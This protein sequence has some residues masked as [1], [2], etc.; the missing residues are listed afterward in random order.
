MRLLSRY[1]A[2]N[3][4]A[5]NQSLKSLECRHSD[6]CDIDVELNVL[7]VI[8]S[9]YADAPFAQEWLEQH[10]SFRLTSEI[11]GG[12]H[13]AADKASLNIAICNRMSYI[14][15]QGNKLQ[16][17]IGVV[18]FQNVKVLNLADNNIHS[19]SACEPLSVLAQLEELRLAGN[20]VQRLIHYRAHLIRICS[21]RHSTCPRFQTTLKYLDG[22]QIAEDECT[23]SYASLNLEQAYFAPALRHFVLH[24]IVDSFSRRIDLHIEMRRRGLL[25]SD[26]AQPLSFPVVM[27]MC[28]D[29]SQATNITSSLHFQCH[30]EHQLRRLSLSLRNSESPTRTFW[31]KLEEHRFYVAHAAT[32]ASASCLGAVL[33]LA[34]KLQASQL[35]AVRWYSS[36]FSLQR[37]PCDSPPPVPRSNVCLE[38]NNQRTT[39]LAYHTK[40]AQKTLRRCLFT[41]KCALDARRHCKR[42]VLRRSLRNWVACLRRTI[43]CR[44]L[45]KSA[46][47]FQTKHYL[48]KWKLRVIHRKKLTDNGTALFNVTA[49]ASCGANQNRASHTQRDFTA[50]EACRIYFRMWV[51]FTTTRPQSKIEPEREHIDVEGDAAIASLLPDEVLEQVNPVSSKGVNVQDVHRESTKFIDSAVP[52]QFAQ[53]SETLQLEKLRLVYLV[54]TLEKELADCRLQT[55]KLSAVIDSQRAEIKSLSTDRDQAHDAVSEY[56]RERMIHLELIKKLTLNQR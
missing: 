5:I 40:V 56:E 1:V 45:V 21:T 35:E 28:V 4:D 52:N 32:E 38:N 13:C 51:L 11:A 55:R 49:D 39:L 29:A 33:S 54:T 17:I 36:F 20:P 46:V 7:R 50:Q 23:Q 42:T 24:G 2:S 48:L 43:F 15:L 53:L 34:G 12:L 6:I 3:F 30:V 26:V 22:K 10:G 8:L 9:R 18:V 31:S 44:A 19:I 25:I 37:R 41:W 16:S 47:T 14:N 27:A